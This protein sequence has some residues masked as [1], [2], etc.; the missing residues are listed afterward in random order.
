MSNMKRVAIATLVMALLLASA[1][2]VPSAKS[3]SDLSVALIIAQGGLGDRSYNDS[4]FAGLT[5]AAKEL[6]VQVFPIESADPVGEAEQ[7]LRTAAETGFD[8]VITLEFSHFEPLARIAPDYP[9]TIFAIVNIIVD[10]PNVVSIMF[11]EHTGSFLAGALAAMV[12]T[13]PAIDQT[14]DGAVLGVIGGVKSSGIDVFLYGYLQGAC[15]VNPESRVLMAYSN[16]FG[17][18]AKGREMALA[19]HEQGADVVFQVAGGTGAGVIE[20]AKD[21]NFFAIGVDSDQDYLA[22]GNVLTSMLKRVDIAV[23]NTIALAA[24]GVL[25]GGTVLQYGLSE[26]GVGLSEMTYTRHIVPR[27]YMEQIEAFRQ[28]ILDG[29]LEIVDIRVLTEEQFAIVD[30]N[31]TCAGVETLKAALA[32]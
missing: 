6:G 11:D 27:D 2:A 24:E 8:L 18:P 22:P 10:Q 14:N 31:P 7:L 23:Y 12:T 4:A 13:D 19:M 32:G 5:L 15:A 21:Q 17:D 30:Q 20:A 25:E 9:D 28:A 1:F 26:G 16:D 3:Q 29:E